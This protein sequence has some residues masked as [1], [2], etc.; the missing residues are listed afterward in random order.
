MGAGGAT[1]G[2]A[3]SQTGTQSINKTGTGRLILGGTNTFGGGATTTA[4][5][6]EVTNN[7]ALGTGAAIVNGGTLE[8][9][10]AAATL[11]A[12]SITVNTGGQIAT[13]GNVTLNNAVTL[14]GG[15]LATRS[16][17]GGVFAGA[18]NVTAPSFANLRSYTT[19]ANSQSITIS[20]LL[21]GNSSLT[22][23]G[24][25]PQTNGLNKGFQI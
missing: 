17:D 8:I 15:A 14:S 3:I 4:G 6:L 1:I 10:I 9:N 18:V 19:P 24:N 22:I 21:S 12:S 2:A 5:V 16:S 7:S 20:G 23:N 13:R 11:T 25:D